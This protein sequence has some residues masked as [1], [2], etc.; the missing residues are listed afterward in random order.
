MRSDVK[1]AQRRMRVKIGSRRDVKRLSS[2]LTN[3]EHVERITQGNHGQ[4]ARHGLVVLTD[5]RILLFRRSLWRTT[6]EDIALDAITSVEWSS[7]AVG[8]TLTI[9]AAGG[10]V[11]VTKM[12]R[13][14]GEA[15]AAAIRATYS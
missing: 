4:D 3:D 15:M 11:E 7:G 5:R 14:D 1:S 9:I 6:T 13:S 2:H 12:P 8:G 10:R